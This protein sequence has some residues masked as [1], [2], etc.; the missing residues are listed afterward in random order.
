MIIEILG[1]LFTNS[2]A[3][4]SDAGHMF[5]HAFAISISLSAVYLSQKP[6][7]HHRTFGLYR[8]EILAAF[9]NGIFLLG[10]VGFIIYEAIL[11]ILNPLEIESIY[12]FIV[13]IIGLTVNFISIS[14]LYGS[15]D[16]DINIKGVFFHMLGDAASSIGIVFVAILIYFT[17]WN[18]LD[19]IISFIISI[20]IIIW[21]GDIL[22]DSTRIL[23]EMTPKGL[24]VNM[25]EEDLKRQFGEIKNIEHTHLWTIIPN[26]LVFTT[27]IRIEEGINQDE[28]INKVNDYLFEKYDIVESTVQTTYSEEIRSCTI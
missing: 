20:I 1:G 12:M 25:I 15:H 28:F 19:P 2:I 18:F 21:A 22:R 17:G 5:T 11:R 27:H 7:C 23:L 14:L 8:A 24:D 9:L 13:A 10:I 6:S 26:L 3:L 16:Q 4:L